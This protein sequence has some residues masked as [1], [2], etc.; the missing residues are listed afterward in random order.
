MMNQTQN[1]KPSGLLR[2]IILVDGQFPAVN[3]LLLAVFGRRDEV[4]AVTEDQ[5]VLGFGLIDAHV[6]ESEQLL[7]VQLNERSFYGELA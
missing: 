6:F 1:K 7:H 5:P 2:V 4:V 3:A